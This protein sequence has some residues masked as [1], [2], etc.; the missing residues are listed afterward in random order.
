M[1]VNDGSISQDFTYA[2]AQPG[3]SSM[4]LYFSDTCDTINLVT[5]CIYY[6]FDTVG[7]TSMSGTVLVVGNG[8]PISFPA[9]A[10]WLYQ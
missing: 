5:W 1:W 2:P 9:T 3:W 6:K 4:Q 7:A 8:T 10:T